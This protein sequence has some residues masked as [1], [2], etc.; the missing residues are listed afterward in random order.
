MGRAHNCPGADEEPE[1][2]QAAAPPKAPASFRGEASPGGVTQRRPRAGTTPVGLVGGPP[3]QC[4]LCDNPTKIQP[5]Q[6]V[7]R[8]QWTD[9][10]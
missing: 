5:L 2:E 3:R 9:P 8:R 1:E 7:L 10:Q 4:E 6:L